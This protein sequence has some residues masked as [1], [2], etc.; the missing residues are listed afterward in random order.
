[1]ISFVSIRPYHTLSGESE[2]IR[3]G[4]F[5]VVTFAVIVRERKPTLKDAYR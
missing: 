5:A 2:S 4:L 3:L 1:M